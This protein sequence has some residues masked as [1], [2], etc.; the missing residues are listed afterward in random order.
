MDIV[1]Q[2]HEGKCKHVEIVHSMFCKTCNMIICAD[3]W[4]FDH[5]SHEII[6]GHDIP[7]I[8]NKNVLRNSHNNNNNNNKD[9]NI[10][11]SNNSNSSKVDGILSTS[12]SSSSISVN[13]SSSSITYRLMKLF[14]ENQYYKMKEDINKMDELTKRSE[15]ITSK[16]EELHEMLIR[17]E[18]R[19]QKPIK[20]QI[21]AHT[22]N[23]LDNHKNIK[24]YLNIADISSRYQNSNNNSINNSREYDYDNSNNNSINNSRDYDYDN[25]N[26]NSNDDRH[27]ITSNLDNSNDD[28]DDTHCDDNEDVDDDDDEDD[29]DDEDVVDDENRLLT[30]NYLGPAII[31]SIRKS[32]SLSAYYKSNKE[33]IL[34]PDPF[35]NNENCDITLSSLMEM[36]RKYMIKNSSSISASNDSINTNISN[37][38]NQPS[39]TSTTSIT[40]TQ[41]EQQT[42]T[43]SPDSSTTN[44]TVIDT[45]TTTL[46]NKLNNS[47]KNI[48]EDLEN[49]YVSKSYLL[50]LYYNKPILFNLRESMSASTLKER[51][52][53]IGYNA[54]AVGSIGSSI[55]VISG[56]KQKII[57]LTSLSINNN[58]NNNNDDDESPITKTIASRGTLATGCQ[59]ISMCSDNVDHFYLLCLDSNNQYI[60]NKLQASKSS[61]GIIVD[62]LYKL[63]NNNI[64]N[65]CPPFELFYNNSSSD[66]YKESLYIVCKDKNSAIKL[67]NCN[68]KSKECNLVIDYNCKK[69]VTLP[70]KSSSGNSGFCCCIDDKYQKLYI[71]MSNHFFSLDTAPDLTMR[72]NA[73]AQNT[74]LT[75]QPTQ[76]F[77]LVYDSGNIY[78]ADNDKQL[79]FNYSVQQ[80]SWSSTKFPPTLTKP[81]NA[82]SP[83]STL[84]TLIKYKDSL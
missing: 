18:H 84:S 65:T 61:L 51:L 33:T 1:D 4:M 43:T 9:N 71:L 73:L 55:H 68:L 20:E 26:N 72:Y 62:S 7:T 46:L 8:F 69:D 60:I 21:E 35:N 45:T 42:L 29:E 80:N 27:P 83:L 12:S 64:S 40:S 53:Y 70:T 39:T 6:N 13:S 28:D 63:S 36:M 66:N 31:N 75:T 32:D 25:N 74:E 3:C 19:L 82:S 58:S 77:K 14:L 50:N 24:A 38:N 48:N 10:R 56:T 79:L 78:M 34:A 2:I 47:I 5:N 67:Y 22:D 44:N 54:L 23:V 11:G 16:F 49:N 81:T 57:S 17:E 30:V 41:D 37:N 59:I 15:T 52:V 76:P